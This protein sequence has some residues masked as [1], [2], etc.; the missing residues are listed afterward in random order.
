MKKLDIQ[1]ISKLRAKQRNKLID[2][3]AAANNMTEPTQRLVFTAPKDDED[4][5]GE[6]DEA[7]A[8]V[9]RNRCRTHKFTVTPGRN[10]A[11]MRRVDCY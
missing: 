7:D 1:Q 6:L 11:E 2:A 4:W 10:L 3:L 5:D 8:K 9:F